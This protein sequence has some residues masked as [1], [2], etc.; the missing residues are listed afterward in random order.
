MRALGW[1]TVLLLCMP[2]AVWADEATDKPKSDTIAVVES[3][4]TQ[5][6]EEQADHK[7]NM[8]AIE[9]KA[10]NEAA[11]T[12]QEVA[13]AVDVQDNIESK[14]E[15]EQNVLQAEVAEEEHSEQI[16]NDKKIIVK[17]REIAFIAINP[18]KA[19]A[20]AAF[21]EANEYFVKGKLSTDAQDKSIQYGE[22]IRCVNEALQ[23]EP[24]NC[25]LA[26]LASQIYRSKGGIAYAKSYFQRAERILG[27][28]LKAHPDGIDI[29]LDYA[30]ALVAG[31]SRYLANYSEYVDKGKLA[32]EK[33]LELCELWYKE[34]DKTA[35]SLRA[36]AMANLLLGNK[37]KC[38]E[39]LLEA[40]GLAG[41]ESTLTKVYTDYVAQG[42]WL[43]QVSP[44]AVDKEFMLYFMKDAERYK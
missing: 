2:T 18:C 36:E 39:L 28:N 43:W 10:A 12:E 1:L 4:T 23:Y 29:N 5:K 17:K 15:D 21:K 38:S 33:V 25:D 16:E 35:Q 13:N 42:K 34:H 31:D 26:L 22:A 44:E 19:E 20:V 32:A 11:F 7:N 3:V 6:I 24:D 40:D 14:P 9:E 27:E 41:E 37:D 8:D 30:L